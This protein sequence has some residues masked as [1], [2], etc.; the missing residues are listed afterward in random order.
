MMN[1]VGGEEALRK[2]KPGSH[3][4]LAL[5]RFLVEEKGLSRHYLEVGLGVDSELF[6]KGT[7]PFVSFPP[8]PLPPFPNNVII[9]LGR[10]EGQE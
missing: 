6:T 1:T 3:E 8:Y 2:V 4:A 7:L 10:K 9:S 5:L